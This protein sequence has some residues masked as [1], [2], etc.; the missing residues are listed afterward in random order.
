MPGENVVCSGTK[1]GRVGSL[2]EHK[3][4]PPK[5]DLPDNSKFFKIRKGDIPAS[6]QD[7]IGT[8]V[9]DY[10]SSSCDTFNDIPRCKNLIYFHAKGLLTII[11]TYICGPNYSNPDTPPIEAEI[12]IKLVGCDK[13]TGEKIID[14]LLKYIGP[15]HH[16]H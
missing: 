8:L 12:N 3:F 2:I 14:E 7:R 1:R 5:V 13:V 16:W 9:H 15:C 4:G 10:G 11:E 6:L